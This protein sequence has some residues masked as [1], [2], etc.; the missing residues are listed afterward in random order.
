MHIENEV[1]YDFSDVLIKPKRSYYTSRKEVDLERTFKFKW[2]DLVWK[3][4]PVVASNM[5]TVGTI[6]SAKVLSKHNTLTCLHKFHTAEELLKIPKVIKK[7]VAITIGVAEGLQI[8]YEIGKDLKDFNYIC[9]DVA[10]GYTEQ[11]SEF[12][13][14]VRSE[15]EEKIIIAGNV[16]TPEMTEQLILSG[17]DIVKVGIGGGSACI[18]RNVAGV[19]IPQLSAVIDCSDAA[20]GVGGMVMSDGG[21]TCSGDI[22]KAFGANADFVM[23]G[24][25]LAGHD[26]N[27]ETITENINTGEKTVEFYGMASSTALDKFYSNNKGKDYKASEGKH[28][29]IPYK[30]ALENTLLDLLGGIRST[31]TYIGAKKIKDISKCTTF[32]C[33]NNQLNNIFR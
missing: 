29:T 26:E 18:T 16:C 21:C 12:I 13:R 31:C 23:L 19:G 30:G 10:N 14:K 28:V 11:F 4:I 3:G 5:D 8:L 22:S 17:A 15:F 6:G 27:S 2:S 24:G 33:V 1:K 32:V 25:L 9:I 7:N 20:H